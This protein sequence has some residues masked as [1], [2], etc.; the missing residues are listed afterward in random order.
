MDASRAKYR[1]GAISRIEPEAIGVPGQR[2]F[3]LILESGPGS[4]F[5]WLEKEQL[6]QLAIYI[7]EIISSLPSGTPK[8][9]SEAPEPPWDGGINTVDF[10]IG[11]LALG[12]DTSS[13]CFLVIIHDMEETDENSPTLSC[14][15]TLSQGWELAKEALKVCAAGRP[16]CHLCAQPINPDGHMCVRANGHAP[17]QD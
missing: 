1:F 14:W 12:H 6:S 16:R 17:L 8:G 7:Q 10:K 3:R 5:L 4:A 13:N 15:L 11:R 9:E 2:T